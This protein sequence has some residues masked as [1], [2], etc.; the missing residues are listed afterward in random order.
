MKTALPRGFW[1]KA[2]RF[3]PI[4]RSFS[5]SHLV[6]IAR[7]NYTENSHGKVEVND[8]GYGTVNACQSGDVLQRRKKAGK[9][10]MRFDGSLA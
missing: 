2:Y 7:Q 3:A 9:A 8:L 6:H 10:D 4:A 5:L 1:G